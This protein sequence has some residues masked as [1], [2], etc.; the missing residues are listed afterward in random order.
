MI[1]ILCVI[2]NKIISLDVFNNI[3]YGEL[4]LGHASYERR[5]NTEVEEVRKTGHQNCAMYVNGLR[6]Y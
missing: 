6:F 3:L 5:F 2:V 1:F 4:G